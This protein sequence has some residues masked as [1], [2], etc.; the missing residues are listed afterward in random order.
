MQNFL[1]TLI[2]CSAVTSVLALLY[3][4]A[5]PLLAKRYSEKWRYYAWL[6]IIVGLI[7][8][9]RPQWGGT[10][11]NFEIPVN[12]SPPVM[13]VSGGMPGLTQIQIPT[14]APASTPPVQNAALSSSSAAEVTARTR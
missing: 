12:A 7:I 8:P 13:Q 1:I 9:F 6:I 14:T 11:I 3:M 5:T 10:L 2:I 4:A